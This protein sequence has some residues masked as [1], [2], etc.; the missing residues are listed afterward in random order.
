M[1]GGYEIVGSPSQVKTSAER[2]GNHR[3]MKRTGG[4]FFFPIFKERD[5]V[6][7]W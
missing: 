2:R 6:A 1:S 3:G 7:Q 5:S 4:T